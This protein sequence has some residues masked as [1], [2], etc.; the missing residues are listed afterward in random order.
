MSLIK[1][2]TGDVLRSKLLE[3]GWYKWAITS[4]KGPYPS[5][6]GDSNNFDV[7]FTLIEHTDETNGKELKRV[8]SAKAISMM[9]PLICAVRGVKPDTMKP[10]GFDF[11]FDE[12]LGKKVDGLVTSEIYQ[13]NMQNRVETYAPYGTTSNTPAF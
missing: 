13:G 9:I 7:V 5:A 12:L 8:F 2:T 6:A 1:F 11:D 3:N 10:E 4:I